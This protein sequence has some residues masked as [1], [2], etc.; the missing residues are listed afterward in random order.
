MSLGQGKA[1]EEEATCLACLLSH[2]RRA[3]HP[4]SCRRHASTMPIFQRVGMTRVRASSVVWVMGVETC[5]HDHDGVVEGKRVWSLLTKAAVARTRMHHGM[6]RAGR[7]PCRKQP[8]RDGIVRGPW[9][10]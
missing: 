2:W 9:R 8:R 5:V 1:G 3:R 4:A 10:S 6:L 7:Q